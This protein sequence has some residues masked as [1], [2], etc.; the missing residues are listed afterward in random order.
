MTRIDD[1]E[2]TPA[3]EDEVHEAVDGVVSRVGLIYIYIYIYIY[4]H[5]YI[6]IYSINMLYIYIYI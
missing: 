5:T 3:E 6:Y 4:I 1:S 2:R